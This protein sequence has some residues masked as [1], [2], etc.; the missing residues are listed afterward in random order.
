MTSVVESF[1]N[2]GLIAYPTEAVFGLGCDPANEAAVH[3]LLAVKQRPIEKGLILLAANYSQLLDYVE[4]SKIPQDMRF[5]VLSALARWH[6]SS[7]TCQSRD[8]QI[9]NGSS[10]TPLLCE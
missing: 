4:D 1:E 5:T 6:N 3:K 7:T 10:L 2:G 8:R 9:F